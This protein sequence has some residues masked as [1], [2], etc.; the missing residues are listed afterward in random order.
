MRN[1]IEIHVAPTQLKPLKGA[2][3]ESRTV[4]ELNPHGDPTNVRLVH[5]LRILGRVDSMVEFPEGKHASA[6]LLVSADRMRVKEI[7]GIG[8]SEEGCR[9]LF[10]LPCYCLFHRCGRLLLR[11]LKAYVDSTVVHVDGGYI[12]L[13][14]PWTF[15]ADAP[16]DASP[17]PCFPPQCIE[18]SIADELDKRNR[19]TAQAVKD[20]GRDY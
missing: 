18:P 14:Y 13:G 4:W 9:Q 5:S 15:V 6:Y 16:E 10:G 20:G 19:E 8:V 11:V 2:A 17:Q 1:P 7:G 3:P 12:V